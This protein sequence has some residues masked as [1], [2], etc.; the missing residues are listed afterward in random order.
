MSRNALRD[1]PKNGCVGD[2]YP[3]DCLR[4]LRVNKEWHGW[5]N[6][7]DRELAHV[8]TDIFIKAILNNYNALQLAFFHAF[9]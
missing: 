2:Y 3:T 8:N 7:V 5:W 6:G 9:D 4:N 1:I